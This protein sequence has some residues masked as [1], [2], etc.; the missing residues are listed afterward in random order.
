[1]ACFCFFCGL[2]LAVID[3][4]RS[5]KNI[6][7]RW[8]MTYKDQRRNQ[9]ACPLRRTRTVKRRKL[10]KSW[11]KHFRPASRHHIRVPGMTRMLTDYLQQ[12]RHRMAQR[13]DRCGVF[14]T[15]C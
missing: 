1:M 3:A 8:K 9:N 6:S 7:K 11:T 4:V 12:L 10:T 14:D 2:V 5:Y 13:D 15:E